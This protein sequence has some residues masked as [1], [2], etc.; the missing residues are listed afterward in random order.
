MPRPQVDL[1]LRL[2][3]RAFSGNEH[4]LLDNIATVRGE[5]WT[6]VPEG[7]AR[8]IREITLHVGLFKYM[9]A[10]HG[11]RAGDLNYSDPP[12]KPGPERLASIDAAV[13]W[14]N[15]AH[16]YLVGCIDELSDDGQLDIDRRAHWGGL[17]PTYHLIV[18]MLEHDLYHAGEINRTR[19]LLQNDDAWFVP[20]SP[21]G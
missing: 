14:L 18:T 5:S 19:A 20:E 4:A 17:V 15:D 1:L 3:D 8:S 7:G 12:A 10:N 9:Y 16:A 11:F 13:N 2:L 6:N 21:G